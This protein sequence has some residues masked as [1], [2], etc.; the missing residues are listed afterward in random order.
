MKGTVQRPH[1][2]APAEKTATHSGP[3]ET[4]RTASTALDALSEPRIDPSNQITLAI[5]EESSVARTRGYDPY[6]KSA[7]A[8]PP[9]D[10]W[11]RKRKRD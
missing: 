1:W 4:R 6:N 9:A 10:A 5:L 7:P 2:P 8:H 3:G 11:H